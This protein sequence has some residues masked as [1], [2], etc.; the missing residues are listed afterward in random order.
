MYDMVPT[1]AQSI[2]HSSLVTDTPLAVFP[3]G[4][5]MSI[6]RPTEDHRS[7]LAALRSYFARQPGAPAVFL[8]EVHRKESAT[9]TPALAIGVV[10]DFDT[11]LASAL[12]AIVPEA[13][14]GALPVEI[15]FI[16]GH[17]EIGEVLVGLGL[18]PAVMPRARLRAS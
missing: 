12:A 2:T 16:G 11:T 8:Y 1:L 3:A 15:T 6:G 5:E 14:R 13:Y 4:G 10:S 7:L 9:P 17:P 18:I